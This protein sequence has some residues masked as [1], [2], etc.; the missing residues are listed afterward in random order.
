MKQAQ[1]ED[2][3]VFLYEAE[4]LLSRGQPWSHHF[5]KVASHLQA[6]QHGEDLDPQSGLHHLAHARHHLSLLI[7]YGLSHPEFDDRKVRSETRN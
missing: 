7:H 1:E 4:K 5:N 3:K 6:F 2:R